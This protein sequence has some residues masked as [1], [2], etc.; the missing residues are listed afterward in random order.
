MNHIV[1]I[2]VLYLG[3][4]GM[5]NSC[6]L[7][8]PINNKTTHRFLSYSSGNKSSNNLYVPSNTLKIIIILANRFGGLEVIMILVIALRSSGMLEI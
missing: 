8:N 6:Y 4:Q 1:T 3:Y 7:A 5:G 2:T